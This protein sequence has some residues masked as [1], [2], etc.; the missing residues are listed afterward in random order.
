VLAEWTISS[1]SESH[2]TSL[3]GHEMYVQHHPWPH[4]S[5]CLL[6]ATLPYACPPGP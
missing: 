1:T 2:G 3:S 5:S 6:L 4:R